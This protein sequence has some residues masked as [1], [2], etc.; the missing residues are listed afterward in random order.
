MSVLQAAARGL[1]ERGHTWWEL[2]AKE[3]AMDPTREQ[4][5]V[6]AGTRE[7]PEQGHCWYQGVAQGHFWYLG[8]ALGRFWS[9]P[10]S[11][12]VPANSPR[13]FLEQPRVIS[14]TRKQLKVVSRAAQPAPCHF[15]LP[16]TQVALP[17]GT[18]SHQRFSGCPKRISAGQDCPR[19]IQN[20]RYNGP[21]VTTKTKEQEQ[22]LCDCFP[23]GMGN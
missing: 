9:S 19:H 1:L 17:R 13:L 7:E 21:Q 12:L 18:K 15:W 6:T 2:C 20:S 22:N 11:F 14:G 23:P 10:G 16:R 8:A 3:R 5:R 4:G